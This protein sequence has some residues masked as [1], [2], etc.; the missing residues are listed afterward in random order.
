MELCR[1]G[2][3]AVA[4][5]TFRAAIE[6]M[7]A[8][9]A[10][11][12]QVRLAFC[13]AHMASLAFSD[14]AYQTTLSRMLVLNDGIGMDLAARLL[15]ERPFPEN[16]NGT[17]FVP[18]LLGELTARERIFLLGG[19]DGVAKRVAEKWRATFPHHEVVGAHHGFFASG[20]AEA[21]IVRRINGSGADILLVAMGNPRQETFIVSHAGGLR[22]S[23]AIGVGALF[24]FA[25]GRVIRAPALVR[26]VR[27]EWLFRLA[28]EPRRLLKRYTVETASFLIAVGMLR[29][30]RRRAA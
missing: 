10:A 22:C 27:A 15:G 23:L 30:R 2:P 14:V 18:R 28:Q 19:E 4:R 21:E 1:I 12:R 17:D 8:E 26:A 24:D 5:A 11:G 3:V 16:L 29:L 9:R 6:H 25:A 20:E 13:N 7:A